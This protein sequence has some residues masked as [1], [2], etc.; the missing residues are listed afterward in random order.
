MTLIVWLATLDIFLLKVK[1]SPPALN[2]GNC[3]NIITVK[4]HIY[5]VTVRKVTET[6]IKVM[7][8]KELNYSLVA[9]IETKVLS[10]NL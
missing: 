8:E 5:I 10:Q 3:F 7:L 1:S 2:G 9:R 4:E 6:I